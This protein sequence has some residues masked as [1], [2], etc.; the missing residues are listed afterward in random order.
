VKDYVYDIETFLNVFTM[1][2]EHAD[3]GLRWAFE[4]SD[5]KDDSKQ[6]I[7]FM[8]YLAQSGSRMVGFNNLGFDYPV[9]HT[10]IRMGKSDAYSLYLK[11]QAI[12]D[13]GDD[14]KF[15]HLVFPSD[16]YVEQIDLYRIHHFDNKAR[17]TSLKVLEFNMKMDNISDLPFKPDSSLTSD[18]ID[19][20]IAYN[21]NDVEA[22][23]QF[24]YQTIEQIKFREELTTK[25]PGRDWINFNDTKIGKE[26]FIMELEKAGVPLYNYGSKGR[27]PRQSK[28]PVIDLNDA[29]LPWIKFER[30]EFQRVLDWLKGQK[31]TETKGVFKDLSAVV[32]GFKVVFGLGGI[33]GSVESEVIEADGSDSM[34]IDMDV[35]SYYPNVVIA[36]EFYPEHLGKDFCVFYKQLYEMRKKYPKGSIEN[37]MLKL[38]LNGTYGDT[39][40]K[41]SV[42]YDPLVT[43]RT[44]LNG[45]LFLCVLAER[46]MNISSVKLIQMN[47]D[48]LTIRCNESVLDDINIVCNEWQTITNLELEQTYYNK[49]FIRDCNSYLARYVNGKIKRKGAYDHEQAW[50]Q[51]HSALIV[52]KV[53]EKVLLDGVSIRETV[54]FW[55]DKYDFLL[56]TK[57]PRSGYLALENQQ[58]QNVSR[59]Y[60]AKGG[61]RLWKWLPPLKGKQDW[62]KF[63]IH[64]GWGV[65]VC[66]DISDYGTL[67]I[68][69]DFYIQEI[70]KITMGLS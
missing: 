35:K 30:P 46:L 48:G 70:E 39:N 40:S 58:V 36:S 56:R 49:M 42:F 67:P 59:Y 27:T 4:I 17:M 63:A 61:K 15:Q 69:Y 62:R 68:D 45:Q 47:T 53:A 11:A 9:L 7:D 28:R 13:C 16:R 55:Q 34:I 20:L 8:Y 38:A 32:D 10:L 51:N 54:E 6:I 66:N 60:V 24:Y 25:Y 23:K 22:T 64:S 65:H 19:T 12:I 2:V 18:Q 43:M 21:W 57:V 41:F 50:H 14:E 31:I 37:E 33:H 52:P 5:R 29:I 26:Y 1:C 3:S 44:T